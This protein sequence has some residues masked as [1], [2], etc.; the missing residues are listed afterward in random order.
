[1]AWHGDAALAESDVLPVA[2]LESPC[3]F[4]DAAL[5]ALER[6]GRPFRVALET[7]S[8]SALRAAVQAG[9]AVTCRTA[10]FLPERAPLA[11][12]HLPSLPDVAYVQRINDTP[13]ASIVKLG[14]LIHAAALD[15]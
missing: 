1:M 3:R 11:S 13:H 5:A 7:P 8:L 2:I 10:L 12:N 15:L 6:D 4:R 9:L 14:Q